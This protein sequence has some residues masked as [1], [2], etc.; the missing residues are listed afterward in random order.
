ME[1]PSATC[2]LHTGRPSPQ[3]LLPTHQFLTQRPSARSLGINFTKQRGFGTRETKLRCCLASCLPAPTFGTLPQGL[4]F[5]I[6]LGDFFFVFTCVFCFFSQQ[7]RKR[8]LCHEVSLNTV[9][10]DWCSFVCRSLSSSLIINNA[11]F[12]LLS[13]QTLK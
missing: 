5:L 10:D 8:L 2:G 9:L 7:G 13:Q 1:P 4:Q 12:I 3:H 6:L 11:D